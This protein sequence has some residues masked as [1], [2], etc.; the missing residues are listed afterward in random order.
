MQKTSTK[1]HGEQQQKKKRKKKTNNKE[2]GRTSLLVHWLRLCTSKARDVGLIPGWGTKITYASC[3]DQKI[4]IKK[5]D[6]GEKGLQ[7]NLGKVISPQKGCFPA[8]RSVRTWR[9]VL[10]SGLRATDIF[11]VWPE[12][13]ATGPPRCFSHL[14]CTSLLSSSLQDGSISSFK[15]SGLTGCT[16]HISHTPTLSPAPGKA[17]AR[18]IHSSLLA[19]SLVFLLSYTWLYPSEPLAGFILAHLL[20]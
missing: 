3:H 15:T 10:C 12:P 1:Y 17:S 14:P 7:V 13:N 11:G 4:R 16:N 2:G 8:L 20:R 18:S 5:K 19:F 6:E 9:P